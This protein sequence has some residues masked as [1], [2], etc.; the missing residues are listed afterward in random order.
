[1]SVFKPVFGKC[2]DCGRFLWESHDGAGVIPEDW[3]D[4][5]P[6]TLCNSNLDE[7]RGPDCYLLAYRRANKTIRQ[8]RKRL[9]YVTSVCKRATAAAGL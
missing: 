3:G 4:F 8:L 2:R 5:D 9:N 6:D 1:M 7:E